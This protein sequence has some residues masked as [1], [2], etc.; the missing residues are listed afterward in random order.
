MKDNEKREIINKEKAESYKPS[1]YHPLQLN[2]IR[3]YPIL[4]SPM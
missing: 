3:K 4:F 1:P 2:F